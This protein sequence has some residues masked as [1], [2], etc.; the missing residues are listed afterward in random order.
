MISGI[1]SRYSPPVSKYVQTVFVCRA[2][3]GGGAWLSLVGDHILQEFYTLYVSR[4]RT[5]K[6]ACQPQNK[7]LEGGGP[8]AYN[9]LPE[10]P[11]TGNY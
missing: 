2:W 11:F 4:F 8:P 5:Y 7:I 1:I 10:S 3:G 6:I 9:Q